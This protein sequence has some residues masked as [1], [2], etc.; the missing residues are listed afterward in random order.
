MKITKRQL[1][2]IIRE[3]LEQPNW[4]E[5]SFSA[6][7]LQNQEWEAGSADRYRREDAKNAFLEKISLDWYKEFEVMAI[8]EDTQKNTDIID[9]ALDELYDR[10]WEK[11]IGE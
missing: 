2:R 8:P 4:D 11:I 3:T 6:N 7:D 10:I 1:K 5:P 9:A